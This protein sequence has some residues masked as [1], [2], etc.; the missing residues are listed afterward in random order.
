MSSGSRLTRQAWEALSRRKL[1]CI[2][3]FSAAAVEHTQ[4]I[5]WPSRRL[6][7]IGGGVDVPQR[8]RVV[9][10]YAQGTPLAA[11]THH[12]CP[13]AFA[14][15]QRPSGSPAA[16][17]QQTAICCV[18]QARGL[19]RMVRK[20]RQRLEGLGA[21]NSKPAVPPGAYDQPAGAENGCA[22]RDAVGNRTVQHGRG[23]RRP[24]P[25]I[26]ADR[27]VVEPRAWQDLRA[28]DDDGRPL[29]ARRL[30]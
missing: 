18:R 10:A 6:A 25:A 23:R 1:A 2:I 8:N 26:R 27:D 17:R 15:S 13:R 12:G 29:C 20:D 4:L 11:P 7:R 9:P 30:P 16:G 22:P 5:Q 21:E 24:A 28:L 14:M 19:L 3:G